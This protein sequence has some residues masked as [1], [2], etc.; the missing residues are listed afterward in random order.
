MGMEAENQQA[1]EIVRIRMMA[2]RLSSR[3]SPTSSKLATGAQEA[4]DKKA[5]IAV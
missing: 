5:Y 2:V 1:Q 3:T 4:A